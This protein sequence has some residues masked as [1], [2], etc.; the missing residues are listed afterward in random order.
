[1]TH[2]T[3]ELR[4]HLRQRRSAISRE[5]LQAERVSFCSECFEPYDRVARG[6]RKLCGCNPTRGIGGQRRAASPVAA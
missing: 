3:Y 5:L 2:M 6:T 4:Q 1:M